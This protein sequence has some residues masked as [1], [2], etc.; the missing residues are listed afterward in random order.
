MMYD[1]CNSDYNV[2][3]KQEEKVGKETEG[4]KS[5]SRRTPDPRACASI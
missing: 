2:S 5:S 3:V 1:F 4:K